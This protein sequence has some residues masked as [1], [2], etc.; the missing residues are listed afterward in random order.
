[1]RGARGTR[2][3][4][5][6]LVLTAFTLT[7][8]DYRAGEGSPLSGVRRATATVLGPAERALG[9]AARGVGDLLGRLSSGGGSQEEVRRLEEE[10]ARLRSRLEV[11]EGLQRRVDELDALLQ[12]KDFGTYTL[13]PAR[14]T[15]V[16]SALGFARTVTIDVGSEDGITSGQ[17]VVSGAGLVGR[18]TQVSRWTSVVL[19]LVDPG[20]SVGSRLT[21]E[22]TIGIARGAGTGLLSY[23]Q[24]E[25]GRVQVGDALVTSGSSTFVPGVPVGRV[26]SVEPGRGA[27][28]PTAEVE[29]FVDVTSLD[30]VG[31][32]VEPPRGTPRVPIPPADP[33]PAPSPS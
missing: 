15:A 27:S 31:V 33:P 1:M 4:L 5:V 3:L 21:R 24:V 7:T 12:L 19:L 25:G 22:G 14:V 16:G 29:P 11:D 20:F 2:M 13:V 30:L 9:S 23:S 28:V 32:V 26:V 6:L 18:T 10:N 17:T 8:L